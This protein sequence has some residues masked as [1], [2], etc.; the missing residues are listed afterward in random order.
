MPR[1][2]E[3][4]SSI[5]KGRDSRREKALMRCTKCGT[6][7][8]AGKKFCGGCGSVLSAKCPRCGAENTPSFKF[9]GD[10]GASLSVPDLPSAGASGSASSS[11]QV[12]AEPSE[13]PE[14]ERK[15]VTALFADI[16]GSMELMENLDPEEAR[17]LVDPALKLMI[18]AVHH[19]GGNVAQS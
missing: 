9:C 18:E 3:L 19:Y 4:D 11:I 14:G 2:Q 17:A 1:A 10:C 5:R 16:K 8:P 6:E 7:N 12:A 15:T 13:V